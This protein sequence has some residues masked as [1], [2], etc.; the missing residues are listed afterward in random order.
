MNSRLVEA[1]DLMK[2]EKEKQEKGKE[3]RREG[4]ERR[5]IIKRKKS[6]VCW[7]TP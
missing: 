1:T 3:K 5:D 6:L 7:H 4:G 2:K